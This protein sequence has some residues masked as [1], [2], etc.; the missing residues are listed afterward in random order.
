MKRHW[1]ILAAALLFAACDGKEDN[2]A[3]GPA[4]DPPD[5]TVKEFKV[6]VIF[7]QSDWEAVKPVVEWALSDIETA[8]ATKSVRIRLNLEWVDENAAD[9]QPRIKAI[10]QDASYAAIIGPEYSSCARLVARESLSYRIPVLM[11]MVTS[12]EFQ[13]IYSK[14]NKTQP[15]IFCL[16][17]SDLSQCEIVLSKIKQDNRQWVYI[18]SRDGKE[19]DYSASFQ[20]YFPFIATE[21]GYLPL[22]PMYENAADMAAVLPYLFFEEAVE[23]ALFFVPTTLQDM[24][25]FDSIIAAHKGGPMPHIYC[26]DLAHDPSLEG[27]LQGGPYEGFSLG[28]EDGFRAAWKA[29]FG[30]ELP[31]GYAQ[32]YDCVSLVADAAARVTDGNAKSVREALE[33]ILRGTYDGVSGKLHYSDASWIAPEETL[34]QNWKYQDGT[35][36][37]QGTLRHKDEGWDGKS[38]TIMEYEEPGFEP[39]YAAQTGRFAVLV[40]TSTGLNNYRH[41]AD[42]LAIYQMLKG[43]GYTDDNIILVLEDDVA[44]QTGGVLKV[45]PDGDNVRAG[46]VVDYHLGELTP[47]D[48]ANIVDGIA[49]EKTP[50]VVKGGKGT[51][52]L[53]FWSGHGSRNGVLQWG[54]GTVDAEAFRSMIEKAESNYRKMLVVLETCY[55]GSI[56]EVCE[57]LPGALFLCAAMNGETSIADVY[58]ETLGVYLSNGFTRA[59]RESVTAFPSISLYDLYVNLAKK[60][61]GS[62]ACIYNNLFYGSVYHNTMAEYLNL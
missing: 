41:Q 30:T 21:M 16:A 26:S 48:F 28:A 44:T 14:S 32:I 36:S 33:T 3:P 12:T 19:D 61:T 22:T 27:K 47:A 39:E 6:A 2:P 57:G 31:G 9:I 43:F 15:N 58:D 37:V 4:P 42:V 49:T 40:A 56:G 52:V 13:R 55:S 62:H 34:Y 7:P 38:T 59:F 5:V 10:A 53:L 45:L 17:Q 18:L 35:F 50:T 1:L 24:L 20:Q 54:S 23:G 25:D 11:P 46:A 29:R 8:Q 51:D 60:T